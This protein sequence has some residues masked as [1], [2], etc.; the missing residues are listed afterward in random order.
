MCQQLNEPAEV[1][2]SPK[3]PEGRRSPIFKRHINQPIPSAPVNTS[4]VSYM[5]KWQVGNSLFI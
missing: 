3:V 1:I 4:I 2:Q 5:N